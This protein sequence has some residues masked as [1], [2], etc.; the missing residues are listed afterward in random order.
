MPLGQHQQQCQICVTVQARLCPR[1]AHAIAHAAGPGRD[2]MDDSINEKMPRCAPSPGP[3]ARE[4]VLFAADAAAVDGCCMPTVQ[5]HGGAF[6]YLCTA[7]CGGSRTPRT[8]RRAGTR[9]VEGGT[10]RRDAQPAAHIRALSGLCAPLVTA[11][12]SLIC[13]ASR[14]QRP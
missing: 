3:R 6:S 5:S 1:A 8:P 7:A 2:A 14:A 12:G 13:D 9:E 11:G 10:P 4:C